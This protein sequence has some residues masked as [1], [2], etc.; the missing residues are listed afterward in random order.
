VALG[1][2]FLRRIL[3]ARNRSRFSIF[4]F[5][6]AQGFFGSSEFSEKNCAMKATAVITR[7]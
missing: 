7:S 6:V 4:V 5:V 3:V 2:A 1:C